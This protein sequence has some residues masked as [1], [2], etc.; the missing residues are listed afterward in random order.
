MRHTPPREI[1]ETIP[2]EWCDD[3]AEFGGERYI[4]IGNC[5][6]DYWNCNLGK[7]LAIDNDVMISYEELAARCLW[8]LTFYGFTPDDRDH[9]DREPRNLYEWLADRL[10]NKRFE[11][12]ARQKNKTIAS[13]AALSIEEWKVFH[14]RE[15]R[16]NRPKRMRDHRQKRRIETLK[17]MGCAEHTIEQIL[18]RTE[19]FN[20][21]QLSYLFDTE[22][23][24]ERIYRSRAYD[25]QQRL[26]YLLETV[27]RYA[28]DI[29][30]PYTLIVAILSVDPAHSLEE[31]AAVFR[32]IIATL[33]AGVDIC[34]TVGTKDGLGEEA[35]LM[36][37]KSR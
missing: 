16:R 11:N 33:P 30:D 1:D 34:W 21:E 4:H 8:S 10:E 22:Q 19:A 18:D 23:V 13:R 14:R 3:D 12:Y 35:E 24:C 31:E 36:M 6:G 28:T 25:K 26:P 27:T 29:H 17:R 15:K 7:Q 20:R 2:V 32:Q 9:F 37:I 5:E